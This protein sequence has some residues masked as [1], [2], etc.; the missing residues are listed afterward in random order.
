L[1]VEIE[2]NSI[3]LNKNCS[4]STC[5]RERVEGLIQRGAASYG[6]RRPEWTW[7]KGFAPRLGIACA[8]N[9]KTVIRSGYSIWIYYTQL[10]EAESTRTVLAAL[11]EVVKRE[12][13]RLV[14]NGIWY[15]GAYCLMDSGGESGKGLS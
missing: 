3:Q 5:P 7:K 11:P 6:S 8:L 10:L 1:V 2:T 12:G 4:S 9:D 15:Y 14:Y 13:A